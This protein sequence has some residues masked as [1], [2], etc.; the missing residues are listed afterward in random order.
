[1][2]DVPPGW[3]AAFIAGYLA[4]FDD[5]DEGWNGRVAA[6]VPSKHG[7]VPADD[8]DE[9]LD[10]LAERAFEKWKRERE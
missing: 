6:N 2:S 4:G 7:H 3:R 8:V 1:M 10:L 5:S 9:T